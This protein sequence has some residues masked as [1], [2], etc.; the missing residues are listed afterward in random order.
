MAIHGTGRGPGY[1]KFNKVTLHVRSSLC[2]LFKLK[3]NLIHPS[4]S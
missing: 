2:F 4:L 1:K 3:K